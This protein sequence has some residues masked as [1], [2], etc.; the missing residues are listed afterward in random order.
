MKKKKK[1]KEREREA[2]IHR[3]LEWLHYHCHH[4][5]YYNYVLL[6]FLSSFF[7]RV[8]FCWGGWGEGGVVDEYGWVVK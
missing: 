2:M 7:L 1:K 5:Y 4:H 3:C 6:L 8:F